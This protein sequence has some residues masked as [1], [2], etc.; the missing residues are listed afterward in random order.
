MTILEFGINLGQK[1][2]LLIKYYSSENDQSIDADLRAGFI[3][4]LDEFSKDLFGG[5]LNL[6]KM[7][8]YQMVIFSKSIETFTEPKEKKALIGYC[9]TDEEKEEKVLKPLLEN[10]LNQFTNRFAIYD[11]FTK[12]SDYFSEFK[13]R[14]D[15]LIK[16]LKL[17]VKDRFKDLLF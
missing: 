6:V 17:S 12:N 15:A 9:I 5:D 11:I 1:N 13:P 14:V 2:L 7:E 4:T 10:V 3:S 8:D 16:D